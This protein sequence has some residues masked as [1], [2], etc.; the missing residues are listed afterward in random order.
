MVTQKDYFEVTRMARLLGR[1][2]TTIAAIPP[3][4]PDG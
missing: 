1:L 2:C 4:T 3:P